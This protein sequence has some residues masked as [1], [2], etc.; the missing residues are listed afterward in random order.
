MNVLKRNEKLLISIN[1][2]YSWHRI[3]RIKFDHHI[4]RDPAD[5]L[6]LL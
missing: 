2:V 4:S 5:V 3:Q 1:H 6:W